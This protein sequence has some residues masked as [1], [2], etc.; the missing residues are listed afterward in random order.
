MTRAQTILILGAGLIGATLA[1]RLARAGHAVTVLEAGLPAG[2][3]SGRS[4]GWINASY[5]A[6]EAHFHL[7]H[8]AMQAHHRMVAELGE[9]GHRWTGCLWWEEEGAA[10]D[11]AAGALTALG[12]PLQ[13]LTRAEVAARVPALAAPPEAALW[14]PGEG[15]VDAAALTRRLL[16][17]AADHGARLWSGCAARRLIVRGGRLAGAMTDQGPVMADQVVLCTGTATPEL[18]APLGL[19]FPMLRRPGL[20]LRSR[21]VAAR[22]G[23]ILAS[24]G[25]ELRQDGAGRLL[26]P[27]SAAHQADSAER[28]ADLPGALAE[29]TLARLRALLP[30]LGIEPEEVIAADRPVPGDG[31]PA[32]GP[33]PGLEGGWLAV[34]HSGVT[35]APLVG[36]LLAGEIAGQQA[37]EL[38]PFRPARL[39]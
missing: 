2:A 35:L 18:L 27:A 39:M 19:T 15:A 6:S 28:I 11:R 17:A 24:P 20:I 12:Y 16:Q 8:R 1:W 25:Q 21:P 10:L 23:P 38:A 31:L 34:L 30:G 33:L 14:F 36:E 13:R 3:A 22:I 32:L 7:R 37:T 29:A 5:F 26:A 4:F 9:T